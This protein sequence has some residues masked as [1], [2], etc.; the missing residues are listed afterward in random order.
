MKL[1]LVIGEFRSKDTAY[2]CIQKLGEL[3]FMD[4]SFYQIGKTPVEGMDQ[5]SNA[6]AGE[7]PHYARGTLG[8]DIA[9]EG[10]TNATFYNKEDARKIMGGDT[11]P[12]NAYA[13][14]VNILD[15]QNPDLAKKILKQHGADVEMKEL[16]TDEYENLTDE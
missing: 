2:Q 10:R 14:A 15:R 5:L 6:Y 4:V 8:S 9:I 1:K 11:K 12:D 7:L 3:E 16:D 13:I